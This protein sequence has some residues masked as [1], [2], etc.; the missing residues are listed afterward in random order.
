MAHI[1]LHTKAS[2]H[3]RGDAVYQLMSPL[4]PGEAAVDDGRQI[5]TE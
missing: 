3:D 1:R 5:E 4:T 2:P